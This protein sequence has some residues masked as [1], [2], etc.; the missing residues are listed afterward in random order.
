MGEQTDVD[1]LEAGLV[2]LGD[3]LGRGVAGGVA[4]MTPL[5]VWFRQLRGWWSFHEKGV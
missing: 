2:G 3:L 1:I 5:G 4:R